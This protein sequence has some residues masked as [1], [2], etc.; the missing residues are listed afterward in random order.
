[1]KLSRY[2]ELLHTKDFMLSIHACVI[3]EIFLHYFTS[4]NWVLLFQFDYQ[5]LLESSFNKAGQINSVLNELGYLFVSKTCPTYQ[6]LQITS[7]G[8]G[9]VFTFG[10]IFPTDMTQ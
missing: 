8:V 6:N 3:G 7:P 4:P 9:Q 10:K 2:I 5:I 1:M